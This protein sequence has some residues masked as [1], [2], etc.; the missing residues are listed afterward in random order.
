MCFEMFDIVLVPREENIEADALTNLASAL[1]IPD[2]IK[3]P[4]VHI[5]TLET[6][7]N[8]EVMDTSNS[9]DNPISWTHPIT[10][11]L[12]DNEIPQ[13]ENPRALRM[14]VTQCIILN[15]MLYRKS[16]VGPYLRCLEHHEVQEV[17]KDIH[18]GDCGNHTRGRALASK[19]LS[20]KTKA[21]LKT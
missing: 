18:E 15:D 20:L 14:K 19:I 10:R 12:Q 2:D 6:K 7:E 13:G 9:D 17:L 8:H 5:L 4:I 1:K 11:Y 16:H 3:I 21:L